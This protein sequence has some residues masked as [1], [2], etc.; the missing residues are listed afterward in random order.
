MVFWLSLARVLYAFLMLSEMVA[1]GG[2]RR[3]GDYLYRV[4]FAVLTLIYGVPLGAGGWVVV[5]NETFAVERSH[6][7]AWVVS[8]ISAVLSLAIAFY[9]L[10]YFAGGISRLRHPVLVHIPKKL[11]ACEAEVREL[12]GCGALES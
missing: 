11:M 5:W 6:V 10:A 2:R 8:V 9:F 4:L 12:G 1:D 7:W 3:W